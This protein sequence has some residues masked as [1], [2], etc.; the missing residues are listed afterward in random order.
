MTLRIPLRLSVL[1]ALLAAVLVLVVSAAECGG[2]HTWDA[3]TI[4]WN[5]DYTAAVGVWTCTVCGD[6][7]M[8]GADIYPKLSNPTCSEPGSIVRKAYAALDNTHFCNDS[9]TVELEM[10]GHEYA[11]PTFMWNTADFQCQ[12][13]WVC[14]VCDETEIGDCDVT[15]STY[16]AIGHTP[17]GTV[18]V[19]YIEVGD[20]TYTDTRK[21]EG[22]PIGHDYSTP[23]FYWS[24]DYTAARIASVCSVCEENDPER[25]IGAECTVELRE[26]KADCFSDGL[27]T[28]IAR[29]GLLGQVWEETKTVIYSKL[30]HAYPE[31]SFVWENGNCTVVCACEYCETPYPADCIVSEQK[32]YPDCTSPGTLTW[33]AMVTVDGYTYYSTN[34]VE[35]EI[36]AKGHEVV[37]IVGKAP[38][39]TDVGLTDG[40]GCSVCGEVLLDHTEIPATGHTYVTKTGKAPTCTEDGL[41]DVTFCRVCEEEP[42]VQ[43]VLPAVGHTGK[44]LPGYEPTCT[45]AG[46]GE[47]EICTVCDEV[48]VEQKII[49]APGHTRLVLETREAT[50]T[51]DGYSAGEICSVCD[52]ILVKQT[53]YYAKGHT[54][55][56]QKGYAATCTEDGLTDGVYCSVCQV[57]LEEQKIIPAKG[58]VSKILD[59]REPT[60]TDAGLTAGEICS[61][62]KII[63]K[64]QTEIP[65]AGHMP[66][67][68]D[69]RPA[70][71][72][73]PGYTEGNTCAVCKKVF[74]K[75]GIIPPTG[76]KPRPIADEVDA[77]CTVDGLTAGSEC[78]VCGVILEEQAVIPAA[79]HQPIAMEQ[80]NAE[81]ENAGHTGGSICSVCRTVL[82]ESTEIPPLGHKAEETEGL[83]PTCTKPGYTASMV[84]AVCSVVLE[85][86]ETL[87]A[88]GHVWGD[89]VFAWS[90]SG[91]SARAEKTCG[92]CGTVFAADMRIRKT[93]RMENDTAVLVI[94]ATAVFSD[95][96][97]AIDEKIIAK[98]S[99]PSEPDIPAITPEDP[100]KPDPEPA[101]D[102]E[103]DPE[104]DPDPVPV[105]DPQPRPD[106][107][108]DT[109]VPEFDDVASDSYYY[110]AV[111]WTAGRG[112]TQGTADRIFSPDMICSRAQIV[113]MLW[114]AAGSPMT[115][116]G[117]VF[118][119]VPTGAYYYHAVLW[120]AENGITS[121]TSKTTFSPDLQCTRAQIVTMLWRA[122][123]CPAVKASASFADVAADAWYAAAVAWAVEEGI[124]LGT[125]AGVFSPDAVC[126]RAQIV[127]FLFRA[128]YLW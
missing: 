83:L 3:G 79:G 76:H 123:G 73:E 61:V 96:T 110:D 99:V 122:A 19:A 59:G 2:S 31:P 125:G 50:C 52:A 70:T 8:V 74:L 80:K 81:C 92:E 11:E 127:T 66:E 47:G 26:T 120:A 105:P 42:Q 128:R 117:T 98:E 107:G 85:A 45:E 44:T 118:A 37:R 84:C 106:D 97:T 65:A 1:T 18:Y 64:A 23:V 33:T 40:I 101:P 20:E 56:T 94:I 67:K 69:I 88:L 55:E 25:T 5:E 10:L 51:E 28:Y 57:I 121:G 49:P 103:P 13:S 124:T 109:A 113:T 53:I 90:E 68:Q 78:S 77:S 12:A 41:A 111:A 34:P 112:I 16:D 7:E 63:L 22:D 48:L 89:T 91:E 58:H 72:T 108:T 9:Y 87:P 17:G 43:P 119:D 54:K 32:T 102:P 24:D 14:I 29:A 46:R 15:K 38:T 82:S 21:V 93:E 114:R 86:P 30:Q 27:G 104:P 4:A 35:K 75:P 6:T 115:E 60:C 39:C 71:C 126:T 36:E 100:P 95:G 62:C 116:G